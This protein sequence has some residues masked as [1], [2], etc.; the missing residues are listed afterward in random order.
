MGQITIKTA[1]SFGLSSNEFSAVDYGHADAVA[2][3]IYYLGTVLLP[4]ATAL[5]HR[6]HDEGKKPAIGWDRTKGG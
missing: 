5:D 1:G 4:E 6:L 3:A 2:Q